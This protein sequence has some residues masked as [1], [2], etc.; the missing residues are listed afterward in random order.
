MNRPHL[1]PPPELPP[2]WWYVAP[3]D[4]LIP[5]MDAR[6]GLFVNAWPEPWLP[7]GYGGGRILAYDS[8]WQL[9]I[10]DA[11]LP[12]TFIKALRL[13]TKALG[14]ESVD[15][16]LRAVFPGA[17]LPDDGSLRLGLTVRDDGSPM[18]IY[19]SIDTRRS[20]T[21]YVPLNP[22]DHIEVSIGGE[23]HRYGADRVVKMQ[24]EETATRDNGVRYRYLNIVIPLTD[25]EFPET[26]DHINPH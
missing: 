13:E 5:T 11:D 18:T 4:T 24:R 8:R 17:Y 3:V 2:G 25:G 19:E 9:D 12:H 7:L 1:A 21:M 14:Y 23:V 6:D 15:Y 26:T 10:Y 16:R 20:D 22:E